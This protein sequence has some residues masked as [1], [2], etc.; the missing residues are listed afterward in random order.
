M[1]SKFSGI[2]QFWNRYKY[3]R[4]NIFRLQNKLMINDTHLSKLYTFMS[5]PHNSI[6][7]CKLK[8]RCVYSNRARA[9][10]KRMRLT[11][12]A[13]KNLA[14]IGFINGIQKYSW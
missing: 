6:M 12:M 13:F 10:F 11:R 3:A 5:T 1:A 2:Y 8:N 9:V 7:F 14:T 4:S